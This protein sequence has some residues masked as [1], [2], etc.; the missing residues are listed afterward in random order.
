MTDYMQ[1]AL[2]W[3]LQQIWQALPLVVTLTLILLSSAPM[4]LMQGS[5]PSPDA[6]IIAVFFWAI[7]AP[8]F[9][10]PWAVLV[11][12]LFQDLMTGAPT[13]F[14][15]VIYLA[16]YGFT[17]SQRIFF[18]G[19]TGVGVWFGFAMVAMFAATISWLLGIFVFARW[20]VPYDIFMQ[21][22]MSIL[23]YPVLSRLFMLL[24]GAL[25]TAPETY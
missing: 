3:L 9:F 24:R 11:T 19:R 12:G 14:C 18:K 25:T 10:P 15:T 20:L 5:V 13:G 2:L 6:G 23:F 22:L 17:L 21:A 4:H 7:H 1:V 8:G 16:A